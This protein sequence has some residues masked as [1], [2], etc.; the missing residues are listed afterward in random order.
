MAAQLNNWM[1]K[2]DLTVP[3]SSAYSITP[4]LQIS[5]SGPAYSLQQTHDYPLD[6]AHSALSLR[7]NKE[8]NYRALHTVHASTTLWVGVKPM[9]AFCLVFTRRRSCSFAEYW[10]HFMARLNDVHTSGYNST[11]SERIW[12]KFRVHRVYCLQL[13]LADFGHDP[14]RSESGRMSRNFVFFL[15]CK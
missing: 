9:P 8:H 10:K 14:S 5:T 11:K 3:Q 15:S 13:A 4:Q 12:M 1:T 6:S 2:T 7:C